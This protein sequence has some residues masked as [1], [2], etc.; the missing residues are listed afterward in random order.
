[1]KYDWRE[2]DKK[3]VHHRVVISDE[4]N[5]G[6]FKQTNRFKYNNLSGK[7][8]IL[9][10]IAKKNILIDLSVKCRPS[11]SKVAQDL[12]LKYFF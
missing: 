9:I 5:D 12:V 11:R 4:M 10:I 2:A 8:S 6:Y 7:I 1:M 3:F